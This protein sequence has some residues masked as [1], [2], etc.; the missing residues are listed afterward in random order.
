MISIRN[1]ILCSICAAFGC[2]AVPFHGTDGMLAGTVS[3]GTSWFP[4][5]EY[6]GAPSIDPD[7]F[8]PASR[9]MYTESRWVKPLEINL[10][11]DVRFRLKPWL[12]AAATSEYLSLN[13]EGHDDCPF[14][15]CR[16][17]RHTYLSWWNPV[18]AESVTLKR[19]PSI[20][21]AVGLM[22]PSSRN[23]MVLQYDL[24]VR[25]YEITVNKYEGRNCLG[26]MN[27]SH[28]KSSEVVSSG[29]AWR[30]TVTIGCELLRVALWAELDGPKQVS[31][32]F[33]VILLHMLFS[34]EKREKSRPR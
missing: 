34:D 29:P 10:S 21:L 24:S 8:R 14:Y 16:M 28:I 2:G 22:T 11:S 7:D 33:N 20:G 6:S 1:L 31:A 23:K 18:V 19:S 13:L 26:C 3:L 12:Y 5:D 4:R 17:I 30:H 9:D 32:G 27:S 15:N 25:R